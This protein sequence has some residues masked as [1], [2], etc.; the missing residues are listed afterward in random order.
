[1]EG[2]C[3]I[4]LN[5]FQNEEYKQLIAKDYF[6]VDNKILMNCFEKLMHLYDQ[7]MEKL[8]L[9]D[10]SIISGFERAFY[11]ILFFFLTE[12][13]M[14]KKLGNYAE[15]VKLSNKRRMYII[16]KRIYFPGSPSDLKFYK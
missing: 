6:K 15:R 1:M 16:Y 12:A 10:F 8:F 9:S 3:F 14:L 2:R 5:Y 11:A 4:P 7:L 13:L